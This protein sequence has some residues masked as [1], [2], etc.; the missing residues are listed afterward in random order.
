MHVI[1]VWD[2]Q[3]PGQPHADQSHFLVR[4]NGVVVPSP[5]A[6]ENRGQH[7]AVEDHFDGRWPNPYFFDK[8]RPPRPEDRQIRQQHIGADGIRHEVDVMPELP[9]GFDP[10]VL[11]EWGAPGL[12]KGLWRQH[13]NA[14]RPGCGGHGGGSE[15]GRSD[16]IVDDRRL[17]MQ[18]PEV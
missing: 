10:V 15:I 5:G 3:P 9:E 17:Q 6:A 13:E 16:E 1:E 8:R 4:V 2:P 14:K 11:A 7:E 12:K 18:D